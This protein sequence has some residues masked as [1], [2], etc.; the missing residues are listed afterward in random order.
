LAADHDRRVGPLHGFG[1]A[2]RTRQLVIVAL[3]VERHGLVPQPADNRARLGEASDRVSGVVEGQAVSLVL[4]PG[5]WYVGP[6]ACADAELEPAAGDDID[7]GGDLGQHGRRAEP[8]LVTI[9]P[10]RS[11]SVWAARA[12]SSVQPSKVGPF[13]SP[14]IG[15]RW[16]NSQACSICGMLS[17]SRQTRRTSL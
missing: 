15:M 5:Q 13:R 12:D 14:N 8:V 1:T 2:E 10:R 17:A 3:E 11:R 16:S 9:S 4:T 6:R 7:I